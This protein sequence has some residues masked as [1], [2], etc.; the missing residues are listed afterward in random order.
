MHKSSWNST[1]L[2]LSKTV[3][4]NQVNCKTWERFLRCYQLAVADLPP[5]YQL[6]VADLL[7]P[8]ILWAKIFSDFVNILI[9]FYLFFVLALVAQSW[10]R[11]SCAGDFQFESQLVVFLTYYLKAQK[12]NLPTQDLYSVSFV[13]FEEEEHKVLTFN[14]SL[15][16][17]VPT[18]W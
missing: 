4:R 7:S 12:K 17:N 15:N 10:A 5:C 3:G 11:D 1:K 18:Y 6:A 13:E 8:V 16:W 9:S 2:L 14:F